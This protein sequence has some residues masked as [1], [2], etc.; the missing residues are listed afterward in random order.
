M[1]Q[2]HITRTLQNSIT[3]EKIAH[4]YLFTGPRGTGKTST[5]RILA[6]AINCTGGLTNEPC[7][8]CEI[9]IEIQ[10]GHHM[11]IIEM[12]AASESGVEEVR[13]TIIRVTDYRPA[14]CRFKVFIID[15]VHDLS[16]KAF[17]ALLKTIEEP[18]AHV[19]FILA[20][21]EYHKVPSTIRS[22]CQKFEF[23][24]A[25]ISELVQ[26]L[27]YVLEQEKLEAEPGALPIIARMADGG[28]RDA[29]TLLEQVAL[30]GNGPITIQ[31]IYD[32]LGLVHEASIDQILLSL[33]EN[34]PQKLLQTLED[35]FRQ[36]KDPRALL[37]SLLYRLAHL[38]RT[39]Y[40]IDIGSES[41]AT[42]EATNHA[43]AVQI[44]KENLLKYREAINEAHKFI[45][46]I[47]LPRLWI[48]A[49]LLKLC[50]NF[51]TTV[52][53]EQT[54]YKV[55]KEKTVTQTPKPTAH[56]TIPENH[57]E[58][59]PVTGLEEA[60]ETWLQVVDSLS[61]LSKTASLKLTK[62]NVG[63]LEN[64]SITIE[65]E[66]NMDCEWVN[67]KPKVQS[68]I[69]QEW[70]KLTGQA[71]EIQFIHTGKKIESMLPKDHFYEPPAQ[72][73]KLVNMA[74]Q[75]FSDL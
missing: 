59:Q 74:K 25:T 2:K 58:Q 50:S 41:D 22:R 55:K 51:P 7:N 37:E 46:D 20:T 61:S 38:T 32:Q 52:Q 1:G 67:E 71:I 18:P 8:Q 54:N 40:G 62:T 17:D 26:R 36:G 73:E 65:F 29:L 68:A 57:I 4:A 53:E 60:R 49:E 63:I 5:A 44:G 39:I 10:K 43:L 42:L 28:Y 33:K 3:S 66:R 11:D 27:Q 9:C 70:Q 21:T 14:Q 15:E 72:G 48:E 47:T 6:K 34:N 12:D 24:R 30:T 23:Q 69:R 56:D 13:E 19:I 75:I 35:V 16:S 64:N 31:G 45:R